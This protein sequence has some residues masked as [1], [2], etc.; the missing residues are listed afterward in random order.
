MKYGSSPLNFGGCGI[1][2]VWLVV[3]GFVGL[4]PARR[5][6]VI[7]D[8]SAYGDLVVSSQ[9]EVHHLFVV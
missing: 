6:D 9:D 1:I 3:S 2:T 4:F 5:L 8:G 7:H